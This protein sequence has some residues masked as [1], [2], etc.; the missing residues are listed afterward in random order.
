MIHTKALIEFNTHTCVISVD[1]SGRVYVFKY[2]Q[3]LGVCEYE[4]FMDQYEA[5]DFILAGLNPMHYYVNIEGEVPL[6]KQ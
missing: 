3:E 1:D 6:H 5:S 2:I 4:S